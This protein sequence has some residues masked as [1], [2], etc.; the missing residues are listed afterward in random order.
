M[1]VN[2]CIQK[3]FK[4]DVITASKLW[5]KY[6]LPQF[7][8]KT[9]DDITSIKKEFQLSFTLSHNERALSLKLISGDAFD[10]D[11]VRDYF[12]QYIFAISVVA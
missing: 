10:L 12:S 6:V 7:W 4:Y 1:Y 8:S 11:P 5:R 3:I 9:W 2:L